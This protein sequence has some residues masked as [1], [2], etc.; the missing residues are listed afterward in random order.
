MSILPIAAPSC[1]LPDTVAGNAN[2]LATKVAEVGLCFFEAQSCIDYTEN[3]LP[4]SLAALPLKWHVHLPVD[5][6]WHLGA[7]KCANLALR[8]MA[9][10]NN[11]KI[12][13][14]VLH[15]PLICQGNMLNPSEKSKLL[16]KFYEKWS[17]ELST[18]LLL[19]NVANAPLVDLDMTLFSGN[20]AP[21]GICLDFGHMIGFGQSQMLFKS[22][23]FEY[24]QLV[25]WSAPGKQDEHLSL[26]KLKEHE[27]LL[28]KD[29]ISRLAPSVTHMLEIFNWS[30][31]EDSYP[32]LK[33]LLDN[34]YA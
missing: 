1:A 25:H 22:K 3:D 29:L 7:E 26:T 18:K 16:H 4:S 10:V 11:L 13:Y 21:F 14:A 6:P 19:E 20:H 8:V 23:I 15:P 9:K 27:Y 28:A 5:L 2:F 33:E 17:S 31:I 34:N 24:I 30:G 12:A 32:I